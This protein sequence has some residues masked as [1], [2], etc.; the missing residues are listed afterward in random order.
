MIDALLG[1]PVLSLLLVPTLASYGTSLN[2]IFFYMTW[3]TLVMSHD[4]LRVELFGTLA[5]RLVFYIVPS[6]LFFLFDILTPSAAVVVKAQGET[7]LPCGSKRGKI[8]LRDIKVAG[9]ALLNLVLGFAAQAAVEEV[10]TQVLGWRSALR[11]SMRLPMPWDM[12]KE[13]SMGL[14]M[15]EALAYVIHRYMLH[16]KKTTT[17]AKRHKSWYHSLRAPFPLTAHYDHPLVYL[18][19]NFIPTYV[20]AMVFRFHLLTYLLYLSVV[21]LEETFAYSGYS[22]MPTN[23]F[24]GGIARRTDMHLVGDAEG[25]YGPWGVLDWVFG[26]SVGGDEED[27][28]GDEEEVNGS[29]MGGS[30]PD[31]SLEE[32]IRRAVEESTKRKW[33]ERERRMRRRRGE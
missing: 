24:L 33:S 5:V 28:D 32:K 21:S 20:P 11:V 14:L 26:T 10:R 9:W 29:V 4:P 2:L 30:A 16:P 22:V 8:R 12:V 15:R 27:G 7:G 13:L 17:I 6:V 3:T 25:N 18:L 1:L 19:A 23:F 31:A